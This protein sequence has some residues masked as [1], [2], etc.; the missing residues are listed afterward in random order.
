MWNF[1]GSC[2]L[3]LDLGQEFPRR[4]VTQFCRFP[5]VQESFSLDFQ[6]SVNIAILYPHPPP[7]LFAFFSGIGIAPF[8]PS[9]GQV[10]SHN[11]A[12]FPGV[13]ALKFL[14]KGSYLAIL[15]KVINMKIKLSGCGQGVGVQ[16][17]ITLPPPVWIFSGIP[18]P[19]AIM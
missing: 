7:P 18:T 9:R 4:G 5:E 6:K 12:E 10:G 8:P 1:H 14:S 3:L 19:L 16:K 15:I 17:S 13:H 11:L 2:F